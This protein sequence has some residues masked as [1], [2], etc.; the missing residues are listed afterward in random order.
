MNRL[1]QFVATIAAAA[2]LTVV[3]AL[4]AGFRL[5]ATTGAAPGGTVAPDPSPTSPA[6]SEPTAPEPPVVVDDGPGP[7]LTPYVPADPPSSECRTVMSVVDRAPMTLEGRFR[8]SD[9][10]V[11]A[12]VLEV[13]AAQWN[14]PDGQPPAEVDDLAPSA[15]MRLVRL[16]ADHVWSGNIDPTFTAS[17]AGGTI[18]CWTFV[19]DEAPEVVPGRQ[20]ALFFLGSPD[21]AGL[22]Q[23]HATLTLW[24]VDREG[25]IVT[26]EDG[27]LTVVEFSQRFEQFSAAQ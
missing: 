24:P 12:T 4:A 7:P 5:P 23:V 8:V 13:G 10:A 21:R 15:V 3:I 1:A 14:T 17:V 18:G 27:R 26:P 9:G 2:L 25:R 20:F 19:S 22:D 11:L 16:S 6:A